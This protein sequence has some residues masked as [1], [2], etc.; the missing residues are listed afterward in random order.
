LQ[1]NADIE[2]KYARSKLWISYFEDGGTVPPPFNVIPTPKSTFRAL[3]WIKDKLC[4]NAS[5]NKLDKWH[6][7][8]VRYS[9]IIMN[10]V[11]S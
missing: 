9:Q 4:C 8:M 1:E 6:H 5:K 11:S 3:T 2:W 7:L 10:N